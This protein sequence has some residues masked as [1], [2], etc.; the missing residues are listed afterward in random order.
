MSLPAGATAIDQ[1]EGV[2]LTSD[3]AI[4][5]VNAMALGATR[6]ACEQSVNETFSRTDD[7][8]VVRHVTTRTV[9]AFEFIDPYPHSPYTP[10]RG[11]SLEETARVLLSGRI[12]REHGTPVS[13]ATSPARSPVSSAASSPAR[14]PTS[15]RAMMSRTPSPVLSIISIHTD[16]SAAGPDLTDTHTS[17]PGHLPEPTHTCT[18]APAPSIISIHSDSSASGPNCGH[19]STCDRSSSPESLTSVAVVAAP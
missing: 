17:S 18:P 8:Q 10:P 15:T 3:I 11:M 6:T 4:L 1:S 9:I 2:Y 16:S 5:N 14:S 19:V 12:P 13:V 7:N